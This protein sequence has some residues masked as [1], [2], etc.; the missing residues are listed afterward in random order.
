MMPKVLEASLAVNIQI[1]VGYEVY[2]T[3]GLCTG[4]HCDVC[5]EALNPVHDLSDI[6]L[7]A[8]SIRGVIITYLVSCFKII[9]E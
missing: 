6:L 4:Y 5:T 9:G 3:I 2:D 7:F 1:Q 8:F